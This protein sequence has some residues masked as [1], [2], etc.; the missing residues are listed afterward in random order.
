M[1]R[2]GDNPIP[3]PDRSGSEV[4][5]SQSRKWLTEGLGSGRK[6]ALFLAKSSLN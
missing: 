4:S 2:H 1:K 3:R 6:I 5:G